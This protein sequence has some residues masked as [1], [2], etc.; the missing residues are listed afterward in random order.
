M[1]KKQIESCN[2]IIWS[3]PI[4]EIVAAKYNLVGALSE[5]YG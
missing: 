4:L 1:T 2:R 3:R 5:I